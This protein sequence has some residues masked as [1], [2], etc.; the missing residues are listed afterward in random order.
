MAAF[1][2]SSFSGLP[3]LCTYMLGKPSRASFSVVAMGMSVSFRDGRRSR[4]PCTH[5]RTRSGK[6]GG[7]AAGTLGRAGRRSVVACKHTRMKGAR[8][9]GAGGGGG[10]MKQVQAAAGTADRA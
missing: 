7:G 6:G 9:G 5:T 2:R 4:M 8:G 10:R 3:G 1:A